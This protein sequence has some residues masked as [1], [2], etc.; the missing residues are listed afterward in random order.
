MRSNEVK[1]PGSRAV[2]PS[3]GVILNV[4]VLQAE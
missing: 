1:S 2:R 4:A 3:L